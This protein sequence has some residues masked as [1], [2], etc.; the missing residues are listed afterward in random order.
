MTLRTVYNDHGDCLR[1]RDTSLIPPFHKFN[2][3]KALP[4]II[5]PQL[6]N[7][8]Y[9]KADLHTPN[10]V[11]SACLFVLSELNKAMRHFQTDSLLLHF[12][13]NTSSVAVLALLT[14][15]FPPGTFLLLK[16]QVPTHR[17]GNETPDLLWKQRVIGEDK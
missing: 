8:Q 3:L 9:L 5:T 11:T 10:H 15:S 13:P 16:L 4:F 12:K 1:Q 14:P 7:V 17:R 2:L 6:T